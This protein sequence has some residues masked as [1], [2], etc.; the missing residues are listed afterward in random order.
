M[1]GPVL[2]GTNK[3]ASS[4]AGSSVNLTL[5][6]NVA[7]GSMIVVACA[8]DD[9]T[10]PSATCL[11]T[12]TPTMT[13]FRIITQSN[14]TQGSLG[15]FVAV[16]VTGGATVVKFVNGTSF[17]AGSAAEFTNGQSTTDGTPVGANL[18]SGAVP[19][20][21]TITT[22]NADDTFFA[23]GT[24]SLQTVT[25]VA[26][27]SYTLLA[28]VGSSANTNVALQYQSVSATQTNFATAY[29]T[30]T[31]MSGWTAAACAIKLAVA[32]AAAATVGNVKI[33]SIG[34][35]PMVAGRFALQRTWGSGG[36]AGSPGILQPSEIQQPVI[37]TIIR[38]PY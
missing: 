20:A 16:N 10:V 7:A 11:N 3:I 17:I 21:G 35:V 9:G 5:P 13:W 22:T 38:F 6:S 19:N 28:N 36:G 2:V 33:P 1:A 26:G 25:W 30:C 24:D 37:D 31:G 27:A 15:I 34:R 8:T 32:S 29:G 14:A 12:S 23:A 4:A 18:G